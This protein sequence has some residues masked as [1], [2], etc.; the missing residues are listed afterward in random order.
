M[1]EGESLRAI[2]RDDGMPTR[3]TVVH[4]MGAHPEFLAEYTRA[5]TLQADALAEEVLDIS[6]RATPQSAHAV[7]LRCDARRWYASKLSPKKYGERTEI[8]GGDV[9]LQTQALRPPMEHR[10]VIAEV[11]HLIAAAQVRMALPTSENQT[12]VDRVRQILDAVDGGS[13]L[14]PATYALMH[15]AKWS[16]GNA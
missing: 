6:D 10:Q 3:L 13:I 12:N 14:D 5:R 11:A 15:A 8:T 1:I 4:W 9:P 7:R 2:C 16:S